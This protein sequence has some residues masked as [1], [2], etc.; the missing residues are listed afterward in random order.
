MATLPIA[1]SQIGLPWQVHVEENV[2]ILQSA[3]NTPQV[4]SHG[5]WRLAVSL[6]IVPVN[7]V[8][9]PATVEEIATFL[10]A[11]SVFDL[12]LLNQSANTMSGSWTV[13]GA[14]SVGDTTIVVNPGTGTPNPGQ[15]IR[16]GSKKKVYRVASYGGSPTT[17]TLTKPLRQALAD[18]DTIT[19][20]GTDGKSNAFD[21]VLGEFVNLD[22]GGTTHN[23]DDALVARFGPFKLVES[24]A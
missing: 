22:F 17:I 1:V 23:L 19:Y 3:N 13:D 16:F 2:D 11:N 12:P 7:S 18:T 10:E 21:G 6:N 20:T 9:D 4:V 15:Y 24:L 14:H 8:A 5:G